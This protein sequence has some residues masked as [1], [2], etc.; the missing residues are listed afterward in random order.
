MKAPGQ[1]AQANV[2]LRLH[3]RSALDIWSLARGAD[4]ILDEVLIAPLCVEAD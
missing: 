4:R 3:R 1:E 2:V